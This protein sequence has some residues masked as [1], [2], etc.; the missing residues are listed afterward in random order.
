MDIL[1]TIHVINFWKYLGINLTR[2]YLITFRIEGFIAVI[3]R[4]VALVDDPAA[5]PEVVM[6]FQVYLQAVN[7]NVDHIFFAQ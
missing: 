1:L 6:A 5:V 4:K 2:Y 7:T 3:G